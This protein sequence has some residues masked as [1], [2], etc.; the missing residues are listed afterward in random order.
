MLFRADGTFC[1]GRQILKHIESN[2]RLY[3]NARGCWV[4][5][6]DTGGDR[7]L[8]SRSAP[9]L[10]PAD[11]RAGLKDDMKTTFWSYE[12]APWWVIVN[13]M[14]NGGDMIESS[15]ISLKCNKCVHK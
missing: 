4:V 6:S 3:V 12:P 8:M 1:R 5:S 11:P 9:S 7:V 13:E 15:G 14:D 2:L 10:C